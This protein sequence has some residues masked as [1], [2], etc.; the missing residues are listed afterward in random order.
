MDPKGTLKRRHQR[1][2]PLERAVLDRLWEDG[3]SDV[4]S[5]HRRV[6]SERGLARNTIQSTLERLVRKGLVDREKRGRAFWYEA[7]LSRDDFFTRSVH[8]LIDGIPRA[9][10]HSLLASFVEFAERTSETAL[11]ELEELVRARRRS[12]EKEK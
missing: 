8:E 4:S 11:R 12:T 2:G 5:M 6:G 3:A 9:D 10:A 7:S 1:L